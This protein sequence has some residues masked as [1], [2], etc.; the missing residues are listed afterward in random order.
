MG[1]CRELQPHPRALMEWQVQCRHR[2]LTSRSSGQSKARFPRFRLPLI[3]NVSPHREAHVRLARFGRVRGSRRRCAQRVAQ[4]TLLR[5]CAAQRARHASQMHAPAAP[6]RM[7]IVR[8]AAAPYSCCMQLRA[9]FIG[10]RAWPS[11]CVYAAGAVACAVL[12]AG[13]PR[14][15]LT[16]RSSGLPS[17][18]AQLQR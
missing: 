5:G 9:S 14:C 16:C 15:E 2:R 7:L 12:R 10:H 6:V 18:A 8:L 3:S 17:A 1:R 4:G 11:Q 13:H